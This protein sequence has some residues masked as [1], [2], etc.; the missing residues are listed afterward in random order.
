MFQPRVESVFDLASRI[1]GRCS[2]MFYRDWHDD[3]YHFLDMFEHSIGDLV[4]SLLHFNA[5]NLDAK[6]GTGE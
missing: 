4:S 3:D 1:T 5:C 6:F 2:G